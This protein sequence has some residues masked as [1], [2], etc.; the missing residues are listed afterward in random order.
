M[1]IKKPGLQEKETGFFDLLVPLFGSANLN[2]LIQKEIILQA[3]R[4]RDKAP[5]I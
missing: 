1:P 3:K 5:F 2:R 4:A